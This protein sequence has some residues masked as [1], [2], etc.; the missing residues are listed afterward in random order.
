MIQALVFDFD[1]LI[2]ETESP[3]LHSWEEVYRSFGLEL[4]FEDWAQ[5]VGTA[6][7]GW[8]PLDDLQQKLSAFNRQ[9]VIERQRRRERE[10]ILAQP[11]LPGVEQYLEDARRLGLKIGLASSST[12]AWVTEHLTRL[13]LLDYFDAMRASDDVRLTKPDP[14]LYRSVLEALGSAPDQAVALE[15]SPNGILAARRAGMYCVAVPNELTRR[16][17][18]EHADLR[19]ESLADMS[20]ETLLQR[21][22]KK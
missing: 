13:G 15:D 11:V 16:I 1:G 10:L 5:I 22:E 4:A 8:H 20:L 12:C 19:L 2:L 18:I 6:H 9:A 17:P 7:N 14:E 21:L 3:I